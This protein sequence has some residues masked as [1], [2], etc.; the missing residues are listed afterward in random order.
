M[1]SF[2]L[3]IH[4]LPANFLSECMELQSDIELKEKFTN[5]PLLEFYKNYLRTKY[6]R[7]HNIYS[8][9]GNMNLHIREEDIF[10]NKIH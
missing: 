10:K 8:L 7:L 6:S 3:D 5:V 1:T 9:F 4:I 2:S